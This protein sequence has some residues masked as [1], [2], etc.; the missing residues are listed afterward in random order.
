MRKFLLG[1]A[2]AAALALAAG[3]QPAAAA[4]VGGLVTTAKPIDAPSGIVHDVRWRGRGVGIG[5]GIL[6]LGL[7]AGVPSYRYYGGPYYGYSYYDGP[8]RHCWYSRRYDGW[9]CRRYYRRW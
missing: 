6:G 3:I 9:V 8:R 1:L 4:G 7:L 5:L 2:G